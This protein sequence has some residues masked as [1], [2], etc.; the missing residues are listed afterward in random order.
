MARPR[1][2][3]EQP[4]DADTPE[5]KDTT[6]TD[7]ARE[8]AVALSL[9]IRQ[10]APVEKKTAAT[11]PSVTPWTPK[12][13]SPKLRLK[14]KAYHHGL[15]LG[16]PTVEHNRLSNEEIA[17]FNKLKPG[18]YCNGYVRVSRRRD[19]GIDIDY[20]IRTNAQKVRLVNDFGIRSFKE[21]LERCVNEAAQPK[22]KAA[23]EDE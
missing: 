18:S 21:L 4:V 11:K 15:L 13:G 5:T 3:A 8:L 17:L 22:T 6:S 20:P 14:R 2:A 9:A 16:D 23:D 1:K 7:I 12:D 19:K 10:S